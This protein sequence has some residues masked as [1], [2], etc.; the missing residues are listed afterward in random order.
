MRAA[1]AFMA[2]GPTVMLVV[3]EF[4]DQAALLAA[5]DAILARRPPAA[6][7]QVEAPP[8]FYPKDA[9]T[10][11]WLLIAGFP[12]EKPPSPESEAVREA[13]LQ[14]FWGQE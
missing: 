5:R 8:P 7:L 3:H 12:S 14:A 6:A 9:Y 13:Y 4:E 11:A 10:G 1:R 2:E